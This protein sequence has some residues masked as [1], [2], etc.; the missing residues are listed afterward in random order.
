MRAGIKNYLIFG[1]RARFNGGP[2]EDIYHLV[3]YANE[4]SATPET[5]TYT[6]LARV[7]L[8]KRRGEAAGKLVTGERVTEPMPLTP[9]GE[10]DLPAILN[11]GA[12]YH[13]LT[14]RQYRYENFSTFPIK[15]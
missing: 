3:V 13:T 12:S 1:T 9:T 8:E 5:D 10:L 15:K 6:N 4:N 7:L 14:F 2:A 11:P